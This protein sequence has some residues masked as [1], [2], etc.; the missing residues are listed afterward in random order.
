M[1]Y[2]LVVLLAEAQQNARSISGRSRATLGRGF[3]PSRYHP[4]RC[5]LSMAEPTLLSPSSGRRRQPEGQGKRFLA[6]DGTAPTC[7]I[8]PGKSMRTQLSASRPFSIRQMSMKLTSTETPEA[9]TPMRS[10]L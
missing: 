6:Q 3:G 5:A 7:C 8:R 9:G 10:P 2:R 4:V 1:G